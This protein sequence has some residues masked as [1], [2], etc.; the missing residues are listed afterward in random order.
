[1]MIIHAHILCIYIYTYIYLLNG[2]PLTYHDIV[3][4]LFPWLLL[5]FSMGQTSASP[6]KKELGRFCKPSSS[7]RYVRQPARVKKQFFQY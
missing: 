2:I 5:I 4:P 3:C 7:P 6:R 1:M